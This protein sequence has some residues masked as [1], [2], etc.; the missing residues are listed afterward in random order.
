MEP[1]VRPY[2]ELPEGEPTQLL[3][4]DTWKYGHTLDMEVDLN[5]LWAVTD[6]TETNGQPPSRSHRWEADRRPE[7][8]EDLPAI[9]EGVSFLLHRVR[10]PRRRGERQPPG[11]VG[12]GRATSVGWLS[13]TELM[14]LDAT[15]IVA[16][17]DDDLI[18]LIGY[19]MSG[20]AL[21]HWR[22]N[23]ALHAVADTEKHTNNEVRL[24]LPL[25]DLSPVEEFLTA[26]SMTELAVAAEANGF[27]AA[28]V[29]EHPA[30]AEK[31]RQT[32]GHGALDPSSR[33]LSPP[34]RHGSSTSHQ[35]DRR[36]VP[37]PVPAGESVAT[38]DK[39]S[40]GRMILGPAPATEGRVPRPRRRL[41]R[42]QRSS[43]RPSR[44]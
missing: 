18:R 44:S 19:Q 43:T 2:F 27:S 41:R 24:G 25:H 23:E 15:E 33:S 39:L 30:P 29:T 34:P 32:G 3:H 36:A 35:P 10:L 8:G 28:Y 16:D 26:E 7:P 1:L 11:A 37:E 21:G 14:L 40:G 13:Q 9:T 4:R 42:A 31:W 22:N 38:L 12:G 6:F 20:P 17:W 5:A